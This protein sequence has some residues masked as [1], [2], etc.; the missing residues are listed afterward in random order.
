MAA[1]KH[2]RKGLDG[3]QRDKSGGIRQ[4]RGDTLVKT[5]RKEYGD[6]FLAEFRPNTRL[7]AVLKKKKVDSLHQLLKE[8]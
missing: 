1:K 3:R 8:R 7:D 2:Y 4:K 6:H 5:L